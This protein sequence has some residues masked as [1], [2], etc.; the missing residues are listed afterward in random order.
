MVAIVL[1]VHWLRTHEA[2]RKRIHAHVRA[3]GLRG[4]VHVVVEFGV[5]G[6]AQD[7]RTKRI[8]AGIRGT[9]NGMGAFV[10]YWPGPRSCTES[11]C[12]WVIGFR[13][14]TVGTERICSWRTGTVGTE[15][16]C[17]WV[18]GFRTGTVGTLDCGRGQPPAEGRLQLRRGPCVRFV[19]VQERNFVSQGCISWG[20]GGR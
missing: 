10:M 4:T 11:I 18:I 5:Q 20:V 14:G 15:R 19:L 8:S 7:S 17:S 16:I 9:V 6:L 1:N 3:V 13:T 12:S 2:P